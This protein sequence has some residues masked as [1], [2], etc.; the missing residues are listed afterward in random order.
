MEVGRVNK[1]CLCS[2]QPDQKLKAIRFLGSRPTYW[3]THSI[4]FLLF[5][6]ENSPCSLIPQLI[7]NIASSP[8]L[9]ITIRY[10]V[11]TANRIVACSITFVVSLSNHEQETYSLSLFDY[12]CGWYA[13]QKLRW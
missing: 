11:V 9:F 3:L 2:Q 13:L 8:H 6:K 10:F 1:P 4:L 5:L 12:F 7:A